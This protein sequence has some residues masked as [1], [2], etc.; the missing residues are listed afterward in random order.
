MRGRGLSSLWLK[1]RDHAALPA[2]G[3]PRHWAACPCEAQQSWRLVPAGDSVPQ[4]RQVR[5]TWRGAH[6]PVVAP[7]IFCSPWGLEAH[8]GSCDPDLGSLKGLALWVSLAVFA[9][10]LVLGDKLFFILWLEN[11]RHW[12]P[13]PPP[14]LCGSR[15]DYL[16]LN[17]PGRRVLWNVLC[18]A[19]GNCE[20]LSSGP[21]ECEAVFPVRPALGRGLASGRRSWACGWHGAD[22]T[23]LRCR[24][25]REALKQSCLVL[26]KSFQEVKLY[27]L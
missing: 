5:A 20:A 19:P 27:S 22:A 23:R 4:G 1:A 2:C 9:N 7:P 11:R 25:P 8:A 21:R 16:C 10:G 13:L 18:P 14:P 15:L 12:H 6:V 26:R 17:A 3:R 24:F